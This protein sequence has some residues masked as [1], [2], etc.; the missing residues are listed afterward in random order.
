MNIFISLFLSRMQE[1]LNE[2]EKLTN[3]LTNKVYLLKCTNNSY[4]YKELSEDISEVEQKILYA[5]DRPKTLYHG[6]RHIIQEYIQSEDIDIKKDNMG[7]ALA[8]KKFHNLDVEITYTFKEDLINRMKVLGD[9]KLENEILEKLSNIN[10]QCVKLCH[11]DIHKD[12]ILKCDGEIFFIDFESCSLNEPAYDIANFFRESEIYTKNP[13]SENEKYLFCEVY[14]D[15]KDKDKI[16]QFLKR[17]EE[18][19]IYTDLFWFLWG[20]KKIEKNDGEQEFDYAE[21][22]FR[23]FENL[24]KQGIIT[25]DAV[26]NNKT[27]NFLKKF[28]K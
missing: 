2:S 8:F 20:V 4:I 12:N 21:Y 16:I 19:T 9:E 3:G 28:I 26:K 1:T 22:T 7:I 24:Y 15:T 23:R 10:L 11:N 14:L 17:I 5:I 6:K 18:V 27:L 25:L 13:L